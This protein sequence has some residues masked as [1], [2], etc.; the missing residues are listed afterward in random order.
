MTLK[1]AAVS[2]AIAQTAVQK[3]SPLWNEGT[4][5]N[6]STPA[7]VPFQRQSK[8]QSLHRRL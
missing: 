1:T 2:Q 8:K 4:C 6:E 3:N 7:T 5:T